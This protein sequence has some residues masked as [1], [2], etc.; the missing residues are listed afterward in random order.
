MRALGPGPEAD[1]IAPPQRALAARRPQRG[2][3]VEHEQPLLDAVV[4][5]IRKR[6]LALGELVHARADPLRADHW[7]DPLPASAVSLP[8][9]PGLE[10]TPEDV[11]SFH[12][13]IIYGRAVRL[14]AVT[15]LA[16]T[17]A[18]PAS[19]AIPRKGVVV[20]GV[21]LGGIRLGASDAQVKRA[22]GAD[23]GACA[24]CDLRTWYFTYARFQPQGAGVTFRKHRVVALFTL[25][26]PVEWHTSKGLK[27]GDEAPRISE[28]YGGLK[29]VGCGPYSAYKIPG[30]GAT[31]A[32]YVHDGKVWGFGL[33][34]PGVRLC[35]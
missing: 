3:A 6:L 28:L 23:F 2:R 35:R 24:S 34:R 7:P 33:S 9:E 13:A 20:P 18:A 14:I 12:V 25:W 19:A 10:R 22:W 27:I 16:L 29:L 11:K 21:R 31:T 5:V 15:A 4:E 17:L 8:L 30:H 26:S 1:E 32:I